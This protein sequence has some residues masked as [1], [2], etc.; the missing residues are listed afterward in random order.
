VGAESDEGLVALT[1]GN[2]CAIVECANVDRS[3]NAWMSVV[4]SYVEFQSL[5]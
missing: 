5:C 2:S 4:V 1:I 3:S